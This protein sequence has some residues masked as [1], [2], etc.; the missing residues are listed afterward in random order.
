MS[1]DTNVHTFPLGM[2]S[3]KVELL[4]RCNHV[5]LYLTVKVKLF[6]KDTLLIY[7]LSKVLFLLIDYL[8]FTIYMSIILT[9][10]SS[11]L[12]LQKSVQTK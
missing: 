11:M 6:S 1:S 5:C 10:E 3:L 2:Y 8:P 4:E 9:I 7:I 12:K